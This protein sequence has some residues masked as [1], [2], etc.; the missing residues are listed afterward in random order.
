MSISSAKLSDRVTEIRSRSSLIQDYV[1][2]AAIGDVHDIV[3]MRQD[4]ERSRAKIDAVTFLEHIRS[5]ADPFQNLH[6]ASPSIDCTVGKAGLLE[7]P[8]ERG[9]NDGSFP[10]EASRVRAFPLIDGKYVLRASVNSQCFLDRSADLSN[11]L[12]LLL[13]LSTTFRSLLNPCR[14]PH[15]QN[16]SHGCANE[17]KIIAEV[18]DLFRSKFNDDNGR[19]NRCANQKRVYNAADVFHPH[20]PQLSLDGFIAHARDCDNVALGDVR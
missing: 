10:R 6:S 5:T 2:Q 9:P 12:C 1:C 18:A 15:R 14:R 17:P 16:C 7:Q 4:S 19:S 20:P 11:G 13:S 3:D 8:F